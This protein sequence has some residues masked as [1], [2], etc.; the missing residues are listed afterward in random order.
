MK[1]LFFGLKRLLILNYD[2]KTYY[3]F[4]ILLANAIESGVPIVTAL[5]LIIKQY[6]N[7]KLGQILQEVRDDLRNGFSF[8]EAL[9]KHP[10]IFS[11]NW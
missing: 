4:T 7:K 10:Y 11:K 6:R 2:K 9:A 8:S 3:A 5:D 1:S